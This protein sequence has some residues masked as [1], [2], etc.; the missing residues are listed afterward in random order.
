MWVPQPLLIAQVPHSTP[1]AQGPHS[2]PE[3]LGDFVLNLQ[4]FVDIFLVFEY[5]ILSVF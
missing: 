1:E 2:T 4:L 3:D 5:C